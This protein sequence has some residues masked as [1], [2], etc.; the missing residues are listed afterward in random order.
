M[1]DNVMRKGFI[2]SLTAL[3]LAVFLLTPLSVHAMT[4]AE[5]AQLKKEAVEEAIEAMNGMFPPLEGKLVIEGPG[6]I[7]YTLT[8]TTEIETPNPGT[9]NYVWTR[10]YIV[11]HENGDGDVEEEERSK[12]VGRNRSYVLKIKDIGCRI[13]CSVTASNCR[14]ELL[15]FLDEETN[16]GEHI[17]RAYVPK[18]PEEFSMECELL[19]DDEG[20]VTYT[21]IIPEAKGCEYSFD[22][23][24]W[25]GYNTLNEVKPGT[26]IEGYRRYMET[27]LIE[28]SEATKSEITVPTRPVETK[29]VVNANQASAEEQAAA[30]E[31][32]QEEQQAQADAASQ[33]NEE[34]AEAVK[35]AN[36]AAKE[37]A[38]KA[39]AAA[40]AEEAKKN[41]QPAADAAAQ[42]DETALADAGEETG[43]EAA[44]EEVTP[45]GVLAGTEE[46]L[47]EAGEEGEGLYTDEEAEKAKYFSDIRLKLIIVVA[48][49]CL[50]VLGGFGLLIAASERDKGSF[51][52]ESDASDD[53]DVAPNA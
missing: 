18:P 35:E 49:C 45:E 47:Q 36:K 2:K 44:G 37:E 30:K 50:I 26:T 43:E 52:E 31:A 42:E 46:L 20:E 33:S 38:K 12:V 23:E 13:S 21:V 22:G 29:L 11:K 4:A 9:L 14:G 6:Q 8:A 24:T 41:P 16:G 1:R 3:F 53:T 17:H 28:Q 51:L 48:V 7:G 5:K 15:D 25:S 32:I 40:A 39:A 10:Y 34:K 27:D 19:V